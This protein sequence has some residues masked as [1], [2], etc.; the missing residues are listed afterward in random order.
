M[1]RG[2]QWQKRFVQ[3]FPLAVFLLC[4]LLCPVA[5]SYVVSQK[6]TRLFS[7]RYL[8]VIVPALLLLVAYG[9]SVLRWR[10]VQI[11]LGLCLVLLCLRYAPNYY[12][13]A[14]VEDWRTGTQWLQQNYQNG[15]GLICYDNS[16]GCAVDIEYYLQAYPY[17]NAHFDANSPGYFPW[18]DYDTTNHLGNYQQALD[19]TAIQTYGN[20]HPRLSTRLVAPTRMIPK[21]KL[22]S[23]GSAPTIV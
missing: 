12:P 19:T 5:I 6:S 17:S 4:W 22:P 15:D 7:P 13:S 9:L 8:V 11:V 2:R 14:Q 20:E 16:E 21:C 10:A 23:S 3:L 18:V 1:R